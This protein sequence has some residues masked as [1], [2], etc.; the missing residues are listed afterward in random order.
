[1]ELV[2][3][4]DGPA[5]HSTSWVASR[6]AHF[7]EPVRSGAIRRVFQFHLWPSCCQLRLQ[8]LPADHSLIPTCF[9]VGS[10]PEECPRPGFSPLQRLASAVDLRCLLLPLPLSQW[11]CGM[12][13]VTR[14]TWPSVLQVLFLRWHGCSASLFLLDFLLCAL[15]F[16]HSLDLLAMFFTLSSTGHMFTACIHIDYVDSTSTHT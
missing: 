12:A 4:L 8:C 7:R 11:T 13:S 14:C 6:A 16:V 2:Q 1:M 15:S 3:L 10:L 9:N 5:R